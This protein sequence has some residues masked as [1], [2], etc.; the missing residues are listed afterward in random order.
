MSETPET[1]VDESQLSTM[2]SPNTA[3]IYAK[4]ISCQDYGVTCR[5]FDLVSLG[6]IGAVRAFHRAVKKAHGLSLK[7]V[8]AAAP[9]ISVWKCSGN[10]QPMRRGRPSMLVRVS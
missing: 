10:T 3:P 2:L 1:I 4:C 8:A 5:G 9:I 7:A 6:D